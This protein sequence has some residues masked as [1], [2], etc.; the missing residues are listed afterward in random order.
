MS[1][2]TLIREGPGW[3]RLSLRH[4]GFETVEHITDAEL[5]CA[6]AVARSTIGSLRTF[7]Q[8]AEH[9]LEDSQ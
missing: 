8:L 6:V 9:V 5:L 4:A 2:C 3:A 7:V 1:E